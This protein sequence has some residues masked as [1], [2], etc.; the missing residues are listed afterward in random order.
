MRVQ[1]VIQI[2]AGTEIVKETKLSAVLDAHSAM[3]QLAATEA[4]QTA[5]KKAKQ[6]GIGMVQL[7]NSNHYGI[8]GYY[9]LL[10]AKEHL[11][12]VSMTNSPAIMASTFCAEALLGSNPIAFAMPAGKYPFLYDGATTVIT[13]GKVELYQKTG[14]Q[15][16]EGWTVDET[17]KME[18]LSMIK[19]IRS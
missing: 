2:D 7:R 1:K 6:H 9:A 14:K 4:M 8:A 19:H 12:G 17:G 10:A 11:L 18:S 13:R 5:I 3:G 16:M 15:L